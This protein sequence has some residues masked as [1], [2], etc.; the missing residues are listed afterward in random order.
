MKL[1]KAFVRNMQ[2]DEVIRALRA[3]RAPGVTVSRV[4]G[5]GYGYD[6]MLFTLS[7]SEIKRAPEVA[8][9]EVVCIDEDETRLIE[10]ITEAAR[11]GSQGDGIVFVTDVQRA[12]KIRTGDEDSQALNSQ[13]GTS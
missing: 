6:P 9:V 5:V 11:T 1:L 8:K 4:H 10:A 7:P 2:V 12:V 13:G 3:A